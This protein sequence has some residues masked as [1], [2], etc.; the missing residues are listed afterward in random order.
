MDSTLISKHNI[1]DK[2]N[3][4]APQTQGHRKQRIH[5]IPATEIAKKLGMVI[6][7]NMVLIGTFTAATELV[8]KEAVERTIM[9]AVPS[10]AK[11]ININ[12][13]RTGYEHISENK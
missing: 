5:M 8:S 2:T 3:S 10:R 13:F 12:A 11:E 1:S 7:A 4:H 9:D 6:L